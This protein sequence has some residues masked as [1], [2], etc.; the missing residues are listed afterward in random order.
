[1][2]PRSKT[3]YSV[4][5]L[6][7]LIFI[8]VGSEVSSDHSVFKCPSGKFSCGG[9]DKCI[10]MIW[11]CDGDD[12]CGDGSDEAGCNARICKPDTEIKCKSSGKCVPKR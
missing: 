7:A 11:K 2:L 6:L 8:E 1:M 4:P 9:G 5:I 12:D 3:L 10:P